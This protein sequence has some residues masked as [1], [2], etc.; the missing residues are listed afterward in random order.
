MPRDF[1]HMQSGSWVEVTVAVITLALQKRPALPPDLLCL[2]CHHAKTTP[3]PAHGTPE[4]E[5][6][7]ELTGLLTRSTD[8]QHK[9]ELPPLPPRGKREGKQLP[10]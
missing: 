6:H 2:C 9:A 8:L 4:G 10:F 7:T 3:W 1:G 5:R